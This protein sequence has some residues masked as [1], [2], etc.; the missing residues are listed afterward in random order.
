[1]YSI[2]AH[3]R[4]HKYVNDEASKC[5]GRQLPSNSTKYYLT[6][7]GLK[8]NFIKSWLKSFK[9]IYKRQTMMYCEGML[10]LFLRK[11]PLPF[12]NMWIT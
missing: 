7:F 5:G 10:E 6:Y 11:D 4:Y 9:K 1:M 8:F 3:E 12:R 2:E